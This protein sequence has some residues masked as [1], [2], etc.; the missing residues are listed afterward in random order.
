[1]SVP[2]V[3]LIRYYGD[4]ISGLSDMS[5]RIYECCQI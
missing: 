1:M 5:V 2:D 4:H 3:M